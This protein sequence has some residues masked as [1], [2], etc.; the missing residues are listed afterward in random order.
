MVGK[1]QVNMPIKSTAALCSWNMENKNRKSLET[2]E[3][4]IKIT[5]KKMNPADFHG[6]W[7]W[8]EADCHG[9]TW[10]F[11]KPWVAWRQHQ[12]TKET[13]ASFLFRRIQE[14]AN[15]I[16]TCHWEQGHVWERWRKTMWSFFSASSPQ[17]P[18]GGDTLQGTQ[19]Q[20]SLKDWTDSN[21]GIE[22]KIKATLP[23]PQNGK[24]KIILIG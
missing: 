8:E 20:P 22:I 15:E 2:R 19:Y 1:W 16:K 14:K 5:I 23:K 9:M 7:P 18:G 24:H 6:L 17:L 21:T 12:S 13:A 10:R 3:I 11:V 4:N